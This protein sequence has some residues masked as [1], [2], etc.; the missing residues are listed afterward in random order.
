MPISCDTKYCL[1][2][3]TTKIVPDQTHMWI[4]ILRTFVKVSSRRI[5][6]RRTACT[7]PPGRD[8]PSTTMCEHVHVRVEDF[9]QKQN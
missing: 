5:T 3:R 7:A 6:Q 1:P 8:V 4:L 9:F 2:P